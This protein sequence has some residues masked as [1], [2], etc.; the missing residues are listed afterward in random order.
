MNKEN[1]N[2]K[3]PTG[4][5]TRTPSIPSEN[6][7]GPDEGKKKPARWRFWFL[8]TLSILL[9]VVFVFYLPLRFEQSSSGEVVHDDMVMNDSMQMGHAGMVMDLPEISVLEKLPLRTPENRVERLAYSTDENGVKVFRLEASEFRWEYAPGKWVHVWGYNGQIPGPQIRVNEGDNVRVIVKNNLPDETT[10]HWHGVDVPW[11]ADGVPNITQEPIQI[12]SEY[13]YEFVADPA[14]TRWYH[15][16]GKSHTTA[17]QQ[18]DMGLSGVFVIEP[19]EPTYTYDREYTLV[20]DEWEIVEGGVNTS[21]AHIHGAGGMPGMSPIPDFNTFTING[22]IFPYTEPLMVQENEKVLIRL[23][24]AGTDAV[25]PMHLHGHNYEVVSRDG[26]PLPANLDRNVLTLHPG[27]TVDLLVTTDNPGPW[28]FHCHN[29]HHAAA[30][31]IT[32]MQYEG[33]EPIKTLADIQ[34]MDLGGTLM[35]SAGQALALNH[36]P[37]NES[38]IDDNVLDAEEGHGHE[39]EEV[40]HGHESDQ[41]KPLVSVVWW[42][43]LIVSLIVTALLSL[44]IYKF[45]HVKK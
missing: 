17:A 30:G 35:A 6:S 37:A 11:Q 12:G 32:L 4:T 14:G 7:P 22:R 15:S 41:L 5:P 42:V 33:F 31:M 1:E 23:V 44:G 29:V 10:V 18:L 27:E 45:I 9:V 21:I 43:L 38:G 3:P 28:L 24:N 13:V 8:I 20:L 16:H 39:E 19:K 36:E 2:M 26:N 34:K 40:D 25:H